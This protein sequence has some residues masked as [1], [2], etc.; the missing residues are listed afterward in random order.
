MHAGR[1]HVEG[2]AVNP[3]DVN[4]DQIKH[5]HADTIHTLSGKSFGLELPFGSSPL[6][7]IPFLRKLHGPQDP[8]P[9]PSFETPS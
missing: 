3:D 6:R 1:I 7:F 8:A 9:L 5:G 4:P 2:G